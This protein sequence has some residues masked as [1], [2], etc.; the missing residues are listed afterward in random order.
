MTLNYMNSEAASAVEESVLT[1][2]RFFT[3]QFVSLIAGFRINFCSL[4]PCIDI[5]SKNDK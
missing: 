5:F 3:L 1:K 2:Q 4:A